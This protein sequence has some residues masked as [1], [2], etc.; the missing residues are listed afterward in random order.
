MTIYTESASSKLSVSRGFT[1]VELLIVI[2]VVAILA[3]IGIASYANFQ[4]RA[5]NTSRYQEVV[6]WKEA[7]MVYATIKGRYP[8]SIPLAKY[9]L[10]TGFPAGTNGEPRCHNYREN[11]PELMYYPP[12]V[13]P[14]RY[15]GINVLESYNTDL[16]AELG[17]VVGSLP[18]SEHKPI[19]YI[20]G[21]WVWYR[22]GGE[23]PRIFT[24]FH[25]PAMTSCP[26]D[27]T[28]SHDGTDGIV[29]YFELPS[30]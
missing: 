9:C 15:D 2:V 30:V 10:G 26:N 18:D 13:M 12:D 4:Q 29:C 8:P 7:F 20:V 14:D 25:K 22:A 19:G 16:M 3:A 28:I 11:R 1:I 21:P 24:N 17:E 23:S 5:V 27:M 6:Q